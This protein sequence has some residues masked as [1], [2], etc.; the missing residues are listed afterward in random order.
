M[1]ETAKQPTNVSPADTKGLE[2]VREKLEYIVGLGSGSLCNVGDIAAK[3]EGIYKILKAARE[4]LALLESEQGE[5]DGYVSASDFVRA[6]E[7]AGEFSNPHT[8]V[9]KTPIWTDSVPVYL[10]T[11]TSGEDDG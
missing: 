5:Q 7:A 2:A 9:S 6:R 4:C 1:S 8:P 11:P 10:G 3:T